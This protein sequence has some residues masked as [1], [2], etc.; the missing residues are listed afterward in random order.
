MPRKQ[1][2]ELSIRVA[3]ACLAGPVDYIARKMGINP[4]TLNRIKNHN[5][6]PKQKR[7]IDSIES[8]LRGAGI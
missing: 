5:H 7:I 3:Q 6:L 8:Y 1:K 2:T 4:V